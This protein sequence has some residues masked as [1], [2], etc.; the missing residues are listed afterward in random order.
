M[1]Y[2]HVA[3]PATVFGWPDFQGLARPKKSPLAQVLP[4]GRLH[5][6]GECGWGFLRLQMVVHRFRQVVGERP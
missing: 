5:H 6:C 4:Q 2:T 1:L 3:T